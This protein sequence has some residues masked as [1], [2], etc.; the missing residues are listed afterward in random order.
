M[1]NAVATIEKPTKLDAFRALVLPQDRKQELF[2]SLPTH[3]KPERF[4]RNLVNALMTNPDLMQL[5]P[6]LVFR[7]V[8]KAAALG[9]YLDPHLAEAYLI[10]GW[11]G[12]ARRTEPQLRVGYRGLIKL[13]RQSGEIN[14][15]YAHEVHENDLFECDLGDHKNLKH[16]PDVFGE[17]GEI[18]GFYAVV[19]YKNGETDFETLTVKQAQ[20]IRDRSDGWKAYAAG[21]IKSTPWATDE[22][23]MSKKTVIRKLNKRLPQSPELSEAIQ[24]EDAAEHSDMRGA[25]PTPLTPPTPPEP[26]PTMEDQQADEAIEPDGEV[27]DVEAFIT[28]LDERLATADSAEV[29]EEIWSEFDVESTLTD[30]ETALDRALNLKDDWL[31]RLDQDDGGLDDAANY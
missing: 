8:S 6:R 21:R 15:I 31:A 29:I 25:A 19:K 1:S 3:V 30:D 11:N 20:E 26:T 22:V 23:E 9:L 24:I 10:A 13:A 5:D 16:R 27:F 4:E 2:N 14:M 17:R 18:V 12:K 28:E 7:E